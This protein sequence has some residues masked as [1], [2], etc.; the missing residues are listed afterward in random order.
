MENVKQVIE[1]FSDL[2]QV[3]AV[4]IGGSARAGSRDEL[5]DWDIYIFSDEEVPVTER[6]RI[7]ERYSDRME[8]DNRF[9]GAGDE[10]YHRDSGVKYDLMF[11]DRQWLE[12]ELSGVIEKHNAK[13]GYT[14]CFWFTIMNA[15]IVYDPEKWFIHLQAKYDVP[16]PDGLVQSILA[17]NYPLLRNQFASFR[18]QVASALARMDSVSVNHRASM[19]IQCYFDIL[20]A[21]NHVLHP[22]EKRLIKYAGQLCN[23][24]PTDFQPD[25]EAFLGSLSGMGGEVLASYDALCDNL[26][27]LLHEMDLLTVFE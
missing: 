9:W 7:A 23:R 16:Y 10:W 26:D 5:S 15:E 25:M 18:Q 24:I 3:K 8:I 4:V 2:V 21:I 6:R 19:F 22:G 1:D 14:T 20:F 13:K 27:R 12:N 17:E 11:W